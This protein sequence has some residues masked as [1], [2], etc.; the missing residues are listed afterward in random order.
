MKK[1]GI[2]LIFF[3]CSCASYY[4]SGYD[5]SYYA[6]NFPGY[7]HQRQQQNH[8]QSRSYHAGHP[9]IGVRPLNTHDFYMLDNHPSE[10]M[11]AQMWGAASGL[12]NIAIHN[13]FQG[14]F[15]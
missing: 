15:H 10:Y 5:E 1:L 12:S 3:V 4:Y 13:F 6:S 2:L 7:N 8:S 11:D 14:F 9:R